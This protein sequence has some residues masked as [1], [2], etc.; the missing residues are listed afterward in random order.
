M[1]SYSSVLPDFFQ[2]RSLSSFYLEYP[3][4]PPQT[5]V[6]YLLFSFLDNYSYYKLDKRHTLVISNIRELDKVPI[7]NLYTID[8][9]LCAYYN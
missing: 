9:G 2:C 6:T 1:L 4:G 8:C 3:Q 7:T 5:R